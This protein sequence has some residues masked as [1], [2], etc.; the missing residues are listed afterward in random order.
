MRF[1][2]LIVNEVSIKMHGITEYKVTSSEHLSSGGY[3]V[4][5]PDEFENKNL[6]LLTDSMTVGDD[7]VLG[8]IKM[9]VFSTPAHLFKEG[10]V[11]AKAVVMEDLID[12]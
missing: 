10:E 4:I 3:L 8:I 7:L 11:V 9:R 6:T 2:D 1:V 5:T 12:G